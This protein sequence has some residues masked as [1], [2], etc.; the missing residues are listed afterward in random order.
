ME[1]DTPGHIQPNGSTPDNAFDKTMDV[2]K[3]KESD[4]W[5]NL[6]ED[7]PEV[8]PSAIPIA[9]PGCYQ[10]A[11]TQEHAQFVTFTNG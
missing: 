11:I 5:S 2:T 4:G 10:N 6:K 9:T 3:D 7:T 1:K 8:A